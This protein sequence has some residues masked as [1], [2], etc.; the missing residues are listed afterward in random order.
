MKRW[1]FL[2]VLALASHVGWAQVLFEYG[3]ILKNGG[4]TGIRFPSVPFEGTPATA[5]KQSIGDIAFIRSGDIYTVTLDGKYIRRLT[6]DGRNAFPLWSP[7]GRYIA[8]SKARKALSSQVWIVTSDGRFSRAL[9]APRDSDA[10]SPVA[11]LPD[12]KG[13]L[14]MV[15]RKG[16]DQ[17]DYCKMATLNGKPHPLQAKWAKAG[18]KAGFHED[19]FVPCPPVTFSG[20]GKSLMFP[21]SLQSDNSAHPVHHLYR[22][23][24][25]GTGIRRLDASS[26]DDMCCLRWNPR[27]GKVLSAECRSPNQDEVEYGIWLR[28]S[29]GKVLGKLADTGPGC[30]NGMDWSPGGNL[31]IFQKTDSAYPKSPDPEAFASLSNHSSIW[32]MKADGSGKYKYV[33]EACHPNWR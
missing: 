7:D 26:V 33:D 30:F 1:I 5:A 20:S 21:K 28:D 18:K 2:V 13:L 8:F 9:T 15:S 31:I 12:G 22:M 14:V 23:A 25:D 29:E 24:T 11:W 4:K 10:T 19:Q 6:A 3:S 32:I 17:P 16:S 27:A